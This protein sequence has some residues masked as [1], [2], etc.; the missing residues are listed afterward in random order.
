MDAKAQNIT[1]RVDRGGKSLISVEDDG[2][3][4]TKDDI[5]L[6]FMR[7][8]TSKIT[9][10]IDAVET[11]GFRGEALASIAF[12]AKIVLTT[13]TEDEECGTITQLTGGKIT[14]QD[15]KVCN[16]GTLIEVRDLFFNIPARR[17]HLSNDA[18]ETAAIIDTAAKI[19]VSHPEISFKLICDGKEIFATHAASAPIANIAS[20]FGRKTADSLIAVDIDDNPLFCRGYVSSPNYITDRHGLRITIVNGRC[21]DNDLISGAVDAVYEEYYGKKGA[22]YILY[23]GIPPEMVDVNIHPAKKGAIF[24][25]IA[26]QAFDQ[27]GDTRLSE[28]TICFKER[29]RLQD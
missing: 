8:A 12:V 22:D 26:D 10:S 29:H 21:V 14:S 17:K 7:N 6:A 1:I 25:R 2:E 28:G 9:D 16:R 27:A 11:L 24:E 19:A 13:K 15:D 18:A 3:G 4:I 23:I 20:L 5:P